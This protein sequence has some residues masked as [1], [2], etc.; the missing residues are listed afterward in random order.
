[1]FSISPGTAS[2]RWVVIS[3]GTTESQRA[4]LPTPLTVS[5]T[6]EGSPAA[7]RDR[8]YATVAMHAN[9][10]GFWNRYAMYR[11]LGFDRF[12]SALRSAVDAE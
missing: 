9:T 7:L 3:S 4:R 6:R 12:E 10:P 5:E 8:G 11:T 2:F 1:M